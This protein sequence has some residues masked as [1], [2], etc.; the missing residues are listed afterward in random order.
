MPAAAERRARADGSEKKTA[1]IIRQE[2]SREVEHLPQLCFFRNSA[3]GVVKGR[4]LA[5]PWRQECPP[6]TLHCQTL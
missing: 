3:I 2:I 1:E 4:P 6:R 5:P